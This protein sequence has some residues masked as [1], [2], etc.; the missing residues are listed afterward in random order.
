MKRLFDE[1]GE[2]T[3]EGNDICNEFGE[4]I[5]LFIDDMNKKDYYL[6]D[7]EYLLLSEIGRTIG[8]TILENRI[9]IKLG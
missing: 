7:L 8:K 3:K 6:R 5:K 2:W 4:L 9:G 1:S